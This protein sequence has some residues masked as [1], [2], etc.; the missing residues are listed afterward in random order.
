MRS[1]D[2][3]DSL[4][5]TRGFPTIRASSVFPGSSVVERRTVNPLVGGSN[6]SRGANFKKFHVRPTA[7][8]DSAALIRTADIKPAR[9]DDAAQRRRS[10][11]RR[12]REGA[13]GSSAGAIP[14]PGRHKINNL[15][16]YICRIGRLMWRYRCR[17]YPCGRNNV[18]SLPTTPGNGLIPAVSADTCR[19]TPLAACYE[20]M[21][22]TCWIGTASESQP[23]DQ[24]LVMAQTPLLSRWLKVGIR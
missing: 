18:W 7:F 24:V 16:E 1:S 14:S 6:P 20:W 21:I 23:L 22:S 19:L 12:P 4:T 9:F 8:P 5:S 15:E 11:A 2:T 17:C 13:G 3:R 10:P